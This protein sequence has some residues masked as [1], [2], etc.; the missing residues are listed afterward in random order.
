M[1]QTREKNQTRQPLHH[2][3]GSVI[4]AL[5]D[6]VPEYH[7]DFDEA[8]AL[9]ERQADRLLSLY[10]LHDNDSPVPTS[11]VADLPRVR[12][13]GETITESGMSQFV[14]GVWLVVLNVNDHPRRQRFTLFHEFKHI[15]DHHTARRL[16]QGRDWLMGAARDDDAV[17]QRERAADYFAGCVLMPGHQVIRLWT[18]GVRSPDALA[19]RF[20]VSTAAM[21]VRLEQLGLV[22]PRWMCT[23]GMAHLDKQTLNLA[24]RQTVAKIRALG[25]RDPRWAVRLHNDQALA[26]RPT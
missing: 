8:L 9:A 7:P 10:G 12:V 17:R 25:L 3:H 16:Y 15:L 13:V 24:T 22:R 18:K 6:L 23:R 20:E 19:D 4:A 21:R 1:N 2:D 5:R 26:R 14:S 11:I